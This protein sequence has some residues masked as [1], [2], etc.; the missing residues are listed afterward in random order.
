[1]T[2]TCPFRL[3]TQS[4]ATSWVVPMDVGLCGFLVVTMIYIIVTMIQC[5]VTS[6]TIVTIT[7]GTSHC[8]NDNIHCDNGDCYCHNDFWPNLLSIMPIGRWW[9]REQSMIL[10]NGRVKRP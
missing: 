5:I 8:D 10:G 7:M 9:C 3:G 4:I 2:F 6:T 1:M